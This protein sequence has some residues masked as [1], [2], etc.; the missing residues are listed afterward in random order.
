MGL[1]TLN[2]KKKMS[3]IEKPTIFRSL[4]MTCRGGDSCCSPSQPCSSGQGDCD[5]DNQCANTLVCGNN[6]CNKQ[7]GL[8]DSEDDCCERRCTPGNPC[9]HAEGHCQS[10][11][12]CERNGFHV[13]NKYCTDGTFDAQRF[14]NNTLTKYSTSDVCCARRLDLLLV[15]WMWC[16]NILFQLFQKRM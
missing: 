8:W 13:C 12:D 4:S 1:G 11:S 5:H 16:K 9:T 7:G 6:N 2:E 3:P 15:S 14:P 10:S